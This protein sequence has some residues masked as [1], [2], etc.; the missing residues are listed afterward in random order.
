M[1]AQSSK[2]DVEVRVGSVLYG[3]NETDE[4]QIVNLNEGCYYIVNFIEKSQRVVAGKP[5]MKPRLGQGPNPG[6]GPMGGPGGNWFDGPGMR[7]DGQWLPDMGG[8]GSWQPGSY[9]ADELGFRAQFGAQLGGPAQ[10]GWDWERPQQPGSGRQDPSNR[11]GQDRGRRPQGE[12]L[13]QGC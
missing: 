2:C 4:T 8:D 12:I 3:H 10:Q 1:E 7:G 5:E 11:P 9:I 13:Y 6:K